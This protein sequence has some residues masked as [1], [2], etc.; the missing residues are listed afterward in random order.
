MRQ[1]SGTPEPNGIGR[2]PDVF[3]LWIT[4]NHLGMRLD[5]DDME[6]DILQHVHE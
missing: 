1:H 5:G 4:K 6:A 3:F 2:S